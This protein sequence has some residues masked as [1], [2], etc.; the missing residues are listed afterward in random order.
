MKSLLNALFVI[1]LFFIL[2]P[3]CKKSSSIEPQSVIGKWK[4]QKD[5]TY[6]GVGYN[7]QKVIYLGQP[8]HYFN[9]TSDG[10]IY[11]R[12]NSVLDTFSYTINSGSIIIPD[13]GYGDGTGKGKIQ[14]S[15]TNSLI[16]SSGYLL[17]PGGIFGRTVY[18]NR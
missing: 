16:I 6:A 10:H 9:F 3:S 7:N 5:S 14:S 1:F 17:T 4:I 18:L 13:F 8:D 2:S 15:S 12:E 11:T